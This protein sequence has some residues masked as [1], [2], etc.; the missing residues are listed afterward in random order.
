MKWDEYPRRAPR[1]HSRNWLVVFPNGRVD[2][3]R[4]RTPEN[5]ARWVARSSYGLWC[6]VRRIAG[7]F[8]GEGAFEV[9]RK[10]RPVLVFDVEEDR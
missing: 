4:G 8:G 9:I 5:V 10:G 6:D 1:W 2:R 7:T 3:V